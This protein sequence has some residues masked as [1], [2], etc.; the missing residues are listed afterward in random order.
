MYDLTSRTSIRAGSAGLLSGLLVTFSRILSDAAEAVAHVLFYSPGLVFG[1]LVI[2]PTCARLA[3]SRFRGGI[4]ALWATASYAASVYLAMVVHDAAST[5][6]ACALAGVF[7]VAL[8]VALPAAMSTVRPS[9]RGLIRAVIFG[10]LGGGTIGFAIEA[11]GEPYQLA[12]VAGYTVWQWGVGVSV[13]ASVEPG[14][15]EVAG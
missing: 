8:V 5:V 12:M 13:F 3:S 15:P 10:A 14:R 9:Y 4:L 7:G 6:V 1:L 11:G 2:A